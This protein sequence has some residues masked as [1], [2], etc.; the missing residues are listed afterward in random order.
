V[1]WQVLPNAL[2]RLLKDPDPAKAGRVMQAMLGMRKLDIAA[3]E[4]ARDGVAVGQD[5]R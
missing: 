4:Q 5:R 3:R 1:S 2:P